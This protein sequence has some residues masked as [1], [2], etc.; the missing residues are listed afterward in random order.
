MWTATQSG[1]LA[2][3]LPN[4][5]CSQIVNSCMTIKPLNQHT[6]VNPQMNVVR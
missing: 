6:A 1:L 3:L 4:N 5:S 2:V